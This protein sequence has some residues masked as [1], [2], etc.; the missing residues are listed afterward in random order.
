MDETNRMMTKIAREAGRF[1]RKMLS[2]SGLGPMEHELIHAVSKAPGLSQEEAGRALG[3]DKGAVTR[4]V[5]SLE[6]KGYLTREISPTDRRQ[7]CLF[8]TE[9][10][11]SVKASSQKCEAF[12]YGWLTEN[13][14]P[15]DRDVFLRVLE[16]LYHKSKA[17]RQNQFAALTAAWEAEHEYLEA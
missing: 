2:G 3:R 13:L 15:E 9:R 1:S 11:L 16:Q 17:Q 7:K 4:M 14:P 10:A 5:Q 8:V 6:K 12:F